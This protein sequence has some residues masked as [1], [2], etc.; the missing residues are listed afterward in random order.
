MKNYQGFMCGTNAMELDPP[1]YH[2][3]SISEVVCPVA[4]VIFINLIIASGI[5][6]LCGWIHYE[7]PITIQIIGVKIDQLEIQTHCTRYRSISHT[8]SFHLLYPLPNYY[9]HHILQAIRGALFHNNV[10]TV[11]INTHRSWLKKR[12]W[13]TC[14]LGTWTRKNASRTTHQDR[15][16]ET[17]LKD[18]WRI[19]YHICICHRRK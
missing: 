2:Y 10:R 16:R 9:N 18:L 1:N 4:T 3:V 14:I 17:S 7:G 5:Y 8:T 6:Y 19:C 12:I 13:D 11:P 15:K